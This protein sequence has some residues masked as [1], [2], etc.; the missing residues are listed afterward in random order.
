MAPFPSLA[1]VLVCVA[2]GPTTR[3]VP[4]TVW[5]LVSCLGM[6]MAL[7]PL[8]LVNAGIAQALIAVV[9]ITAALFVVAVNF[10]KEIA[11]LY[12]DERHSSNTEEAP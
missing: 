1:R 6:G 9:F 3:R 8:L 7:T 5:T 2:H 4:L 11:Q 10:S 12:L